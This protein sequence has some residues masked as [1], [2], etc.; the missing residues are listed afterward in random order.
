[1]TNYKHI[2]KVNY[3]DHIKKVTICVTEFL[4]NYHKPINDIAH[5]VTDVRRIVLD[6]TIKRTFQVFK[7]CR[8]INS[9]HG[10]VM[11]VAWTRFGKILKK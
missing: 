4:R 6:L 1:M 2:Q 9:Q 3:R 10:Q 11:A 5:T 7:I 8:G